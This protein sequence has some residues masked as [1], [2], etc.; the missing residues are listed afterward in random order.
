MTDFGAVGDGHTLDTVAIN[1][2]IAAC[3][4]A[5]GGVVHFTAGTYLI[6][7]IEL[8]SRVTLQLDAGAVI[9][10]SA[11]LADYRQL[12]TASEGRDTALIV[13]VDAQNVAITGHG[14]IDGNGRAFALPGEADVSRDFDAHHT[15]QGA[16]YLKLNDR[17]EDGRCG[18]EC[19]RESSRCFCAARR[20]TFPRYGSWTRRTGDCMWRAAR[21]CC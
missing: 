21:T 17:P 13:A 16:A 14:T 11:A 20:S 12:P 18:I 2:T 3:H 19:G 6:G 9:K 15:R 10:G 1:R 4:D 8:L 7:T 5:G